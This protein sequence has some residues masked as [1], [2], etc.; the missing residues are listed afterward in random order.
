MAKTRRK[1]DLYLTLLSKAEKLFKEA[2]DRRAAAHIFLGRAIKLLNKE[3]K[4]GK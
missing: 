4:N 3:V 2:E 1:E